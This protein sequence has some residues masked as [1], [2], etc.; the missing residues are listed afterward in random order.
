MDHRQIRDVP[1]LSIVCLCVALLAQSHAA[2]HIQGRATASSGQDAYSPDKAIDGDRTTRWSSA[3]TDDAW[4]QIAFAQPQSLAGLQI[5]WETAYGEQYAIQVS[6]D[7]THWRTVTVETAGDGK[8]DWLFFEPLTTRFLRLQG[9][10]RGTG[11]GYSI[12]EVTLLHAHAWPTIQVSHPLAGSD[13]QR[14][15]DGQPTTY[16]HSPPHDHQ[17]VVIT[18]PSPMTLGGLELVWGAHFPT[19]YAIE[20]D[21]ADGQWQRVKHV[22]QGN[23]GQ[24]G[25]YFPARQAARIRLRLEQTHRGQG[26]ALGEIKLKS[27]EEQ[28]TPLRVYQALA[29]ER[30]SGWYPRWMQREQEFWTITGVVG[31][32][33]ESLLSESGVVEPYKESFSVMPFVHLGDRLIS[34]ADVKTEQGLEAAYLPLPHVVWTADTWSLHITTV[35]FG[36]AGASSTAVRYRLRNHGSQALRGRLILAIRPLQLNP[37]WQAG[38][39]SPIR[40]LATGPHA[41]GQY[42]RINARTRVLAPAVPAQ[43]VLLTYDQGTVLDCLRQAACPAGR[44]VK[45]DEGKSEAA[46]VYEI[47]LAPGAHAE[48][49]LLLPLHDTLPA[50]TAWQNPSAAFARHIDAQRRQWHTLLERVS[51][52][53]PEP[54]L[55][56]MLRSNLAYILLNQDGPWIKP[57]S[58]KYNHSWMRDGAM[59][60]LALLRMG[61]TEPVRQFVRTTIA[62]VDKNGWVPWLI[63]DG[64]RPVGFV[65][66]SRE[67]HEYDSQGQFPF[68]V[69]H[70]VSYTNDDSVLP[71]AYPAVMRALR[72]GSQL[73]RERMTQ[74]YQTQPERQA[75]YG[76]LPESNSHEGYYPAMH[77]YWDDFWYLRGLKDGLYLADRT[78]NH[79]DA[80]WIRAELHDARNALYTSMRR[81]IARDQLTYLPGSVEKGDFDAT[82]TAI[83]I[84]VGDEA[85]MLPQPYATHTFDR[86]YGHFVQRLQPGKATTFT[87]YEVRI[88][89]AFVRLGQRQRALEILR[90]FTYDTPQPPAWN[91]LPEVVH[92]RPRAPSYIGDMPHTWVGSGYISAIRSLF[93]Y[94]EGDRL[95]LAAGIDPAWIH[96]GITVRQLPTLFGTIAYD[97][98][99]VDG[100]IRIHIRGR[101]APPGGFTVR[102][103]PEFPIKTARLNGAVV[104]HTDGSF[105]FAT[106]PTLVELQTVAE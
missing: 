80:A 86:Y 87:P 15:V 90:T 43:T 45:D 81:V 72:Y 37:I 16:W 57:G 22:T 78:G 85:A 26:V 101:A 2:R 30:P 7:G 32:T 5:L 31:D 51:L 104:A 74:A 40:T 42:V 60:S 41:T 59:T 54:K 3:F 95:I 61:L 46:L 10:Q 8:T 68:L 70:Y 62:L 28:A 18:L 11:W 79:D 97:I 24:D 99:N 63:F 58:R 14:I 6:D 64:G 76:I 71:E 56:Q 38:G 53:I 89:E 84:M 47:N 34:W 4:W 91:Q 77:S 12:W 83:A 75:Y 98:R 13:P 48:Y 103:P 50:L 88:A 27:G 1:L 82:S 73:R 66:D 102:L 55:I 100:R 25:L 9:R 69:R 52:T 23:G 17:D 33:Q 106:L 19:A 67:G 21:M 29:R 49:V 93:A 105:H 39:F 44:S 65:S 96:E 35:S 20:L 92:G 94:E 36:S